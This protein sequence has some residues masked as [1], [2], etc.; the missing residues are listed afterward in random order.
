MNKEI[1]AKFFIDDKEKLRSILT[2]ID[3]SLI[4]KEFMMKR[5]T[6]NCDHNGEWIRVR[7]EGDKITM[8]YKNII[9]NT[10]QGVN[11]IEITVNDFD[12]A[13]DLINQTNFKETSYQ[14]NFREIWRNDECEVVIDTW[15]YLQNYIEIEALEEDIVRKYSELLGFNFDEE[16]YFGGVETLYNKQFGISKED[17]CK[18]DKIT[19]N[20][21][22]LKSILKI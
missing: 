9:N 10:I 5:K 21:E 6:F 4:K 1:E 12:K 11:E 20:D 17:F 2:S 3:F 14:E 19:F 7:D 13:S 16:A 8:T 22:K 18:I 15:P